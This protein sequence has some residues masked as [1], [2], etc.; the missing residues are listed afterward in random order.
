VE[1][2]ITNKKYMRNEIWSLISYKGAPSWFITFSPADNRHPI[3]LY[4]A[5][6]M[7]EFSPSIRASDECYRLIANNPVA[8]A[9]FFN[10]MVE[11]FIEHVLGV[12]QKH[13]GVYG[14]TSA[15]YGTVE[16]QGRLT[17]HLHLLLWIRGALTP[18]EIRDRIMDPNSDFQKKMVEYLE[19]VHQGEFMNGTMDDVRDG[20]DLAEK[21]PRYLPPT[22]TL[23][24]CPPPKCPHK[25]CSGCFFCTCLGL[26]W[27]KFNYVVDDLLWRSNIH[28][29]GPRCYSD[30]RESCKSRFPRDLYPETLVDPDTGALNMKKG[31]AHMNT[32]T[33]ILTYLIRC[34]SDVT[35]LLS[36]T[37]VKAVVA[38]VTEYVTKPGLKTYSIFDT[39]RSVF[40]RN[41][42]LIGGDHKRQE[43]ARCVLTQIVNALTAKI[44]GPMAAMYLLK[45]PDHYTSHIFKVFYW[46]SYV[47]EVRS[48]WM[49]HDQDIKDENEPSQEENVII[50]KIGDKYF[51][52]S[53]V[54]DYKY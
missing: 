20:I 32:V 37:A 47:R 17:L 48:V 34:N 12:G 14:D 39:I 43:K 38:Y 18:Q 3:C 6:T 16:Q 53:A 54:D 35:S 52:I 11:A 50:E 7:E 1:G 30:G 2:S 19:S 24:D 13:R 8:G 26:W 29:C 28:E 45:H 25:K 51:G 49:D 10:F 31:G 40:D 22:M 42:E 33:P 46:K 27:H 36:G 23:P 41:S 21:E 4:F 15:Y 5:D 44:D 9:R